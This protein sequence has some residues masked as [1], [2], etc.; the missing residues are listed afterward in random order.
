[1]SLLPLLL[2]AI[3]AIAQQAP[4]AG[5]LL[6]QQPKLPSL[7][8]APPAQDLTP[9]AA[10]PQAESAGPRVLVK[11]F[12][13][14][15]ATLVA[16]GELQAQ[17]AEAVGKEYSFQQL[18]GMALQLIGYYAQKGYLARVFIAPQGF[19]DGTVTFTIV[20]GKL[21][22]LK[23]DTNIDSSRID[24][25]RL[26]RFL[27]AR[28]Q[29]GEKLSLA[30]VGETMNVLN[31]QPGIQA[32]AALKPGKGEGEIDLTI[33]ATATPPTSY[34]FQLNNSGTRAT[35]ELQLTGNLALNNPIGHFDRA[36]LLFNAA[37]GIAF[38]NG[39]Y[40]IAVGD[41]GLRLGANASK[42][43]Y[44]VTES[45]QSALQGKGH[46]DTLGVYA[47][48]PLERLTQSQLTLTTSLNRRHMKDD[49][50][51]VE[52]SNR[53][54]TVGNIAVSGWRFNPAL[55]G[56]TNYGLDL[57]TGK[58]DRSGNAGD[59]NQDQLGRRSDG[60][61]TKLAWRAGHFAP[62]ADSW[63]LYAN[64]S[65]QFTNRNLESSERF[66]LGG[67]NGVRA[68][69]VSEGSG[70]EGWLL[71]LNLSH[72]IGDTLAVKFFIDHGQIRL[73]KTLW[74]GWNDGNPN[75]PNRYALSGIGGSID[76]EIDKN[77][78]LGVTLAVPLGKNP[79]RDSTGLDADGRHTNARLWAGL[80]ANF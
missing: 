12:R 54:V 59:L 63:N 42:L 64:L 78:S 1:L 8:S 66:T 19:T 33:A 24:A 7:P 60:G 77:L 32:R 3:P 45:S 11:G 53:T 39:D 79:G 44:R 22:E 14:A 51:A 31:E 15:G 43:R 6:R 62:L 34:G 70:D 30:A 4:D 52:T 16:E 20:E 73:N 37:D 5:Q 55:A 13:F 67:P 71:N 28:L 50:V 57:S 41:R 18:Q 46:A 65:G 47:S 40:G 26:Q 58:T 48:Y 69:P 23:L 75:Q 36:V 29:P 61:F 74:A 9:K 76:W 80:S 21:G 17:L 56:V 27:A 25:A 49:A 35:G 2:A 10:E 38:L 72:P 68:Y